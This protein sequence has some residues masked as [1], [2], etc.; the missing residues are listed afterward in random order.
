MVGA[1]QLAA[2]GTTTGAA[3]LTLVVPIALVIVVLGIWWV[4]LR[5]GRSRTAEVASATPVLRE[6]PPA[7]EGP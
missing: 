6:D 4:A 2:A 3:L 7:L 5:R 1:L